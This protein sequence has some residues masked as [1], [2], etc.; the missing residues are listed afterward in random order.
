[1]VSRQ[2]LCALES[3]VYPEERPVQD[4]S[5]SAAPFGLGAGGRRVSQCQAG[6]AQQGAI[7]VFRRFSGLS[8]VPDSCSEGLGGQRKLPTL[9][10][11]G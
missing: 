9:A 1:M 6:C 2:V 8:L 4:G 5:S 7:L 10:F 3:P 11:L